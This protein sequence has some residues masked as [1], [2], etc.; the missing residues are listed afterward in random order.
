MTIEA[1]INPDFSTSEK[2]FFLFLTFIGVLLCIIVIVAIAKVAAAGIVK[3]QL[4]ENGNKAAVGGSVFVN[5]IYRRVQLFYEMLI[6]GT[7]VLSFSCA[8]VIAN[9]L[10]TLLLYHGQSAT[11][12]SFRHWIAAWENGKDFILLLMICGSCVLNTILDRLI[13]PLKHTSK[14]EKASIRLLAMFY[15]IAILLCLNQVGDESEYSPVMMYYLGLMIGRFVYFDASFMDFLMAIKRALKNAYLLILGLMLTGS[16]CV[17]GFRQEYLLPR[18]YYI[19][20]VFYTH[21][22]MLTAIFLLHHLRVIKKITLKIVGG[23]EAVKEKKDDGE[24]ESGSGS[25]ERQ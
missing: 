8:Y 16:L 10:Y 7:S 4:E 13:I 15:V 6:S 18:N 3:K 22:F 21:L 5:E 1:Y 20:G 2:L 17:I 9:H 24:G 23:A 25:A 19:V 12:G 14:D 11:S